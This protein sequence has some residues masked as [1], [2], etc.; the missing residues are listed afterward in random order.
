MENRIATICENI[1]NAS[2]Y[3]EAV[4]LANISIRVAREAYNVSP[5]EEWFISTYR[6]LMFK[7]CS[8]DMPAFVFSELRRRIASCYTCNA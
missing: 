5:R 7:A 3:R 4:R 1:I 8:E 2:D 6:A